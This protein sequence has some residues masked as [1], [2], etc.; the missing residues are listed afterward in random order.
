MEAAFA[1]ALGL[2]LGGPLSY[3]ERHEDRPTLGDGRAPTPADARRAARLSLA[4]GA[5]AALV[6]AA[7]RSIGQE[8]T[9]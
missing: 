5:G 3:G 9:A 6:C 8:A 1:G 2:Q 7:A 4:V